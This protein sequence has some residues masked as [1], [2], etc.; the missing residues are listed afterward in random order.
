MFI[1][2]Y[3]PW[4]FSFNKENS[5]NEIKEENIIT[6]DCSNKNE[7]NEKE[8][9]NIDYG[10]IGEEL[11]NFF[12]GTR[13]IREISIKQAIIFEELNFTKNEDFIK[14][15]NINKYFRIK[16]PNITLMNSSSDISSGYIILGGDC[17]FAIERGLSIYS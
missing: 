12:F 16:E 8:N 5:F 15:K 2:N 17:F 11:I 3:Y 1:F 10:E 4:N 7:K 6:N 9:D 13:V 14:L